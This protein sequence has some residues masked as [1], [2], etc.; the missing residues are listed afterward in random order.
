M[1][2]NHL[3]EELERVKALGGLVLYSRDNP[4]QDPPKIVF[5]TFQRIVDAELP[6]KLLDEPH[7]A[8][9]SGFKDNAT[10][11]MMASHAGVVEL[12]KDLI[13][14]GAE[15]EARDADG[16]TAL[17]YAANMGRD[18]VV[19]LLLQ[20]GADVNAMDNH[21]STPVMFAAQ[22]DH[23]SAVKR[24]ID[25]RAD[26]SIRGDHGLTALGF[27]KQNGHRKTRRILERAGATP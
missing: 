17:M 10:S 25:A 15:I 8:V 11:L 18:E 6:M 27:A 1:T 24:L 21:Q 12:V 23:V 26:L 20:A 4:D 16:Y 14:R 22:H 19:D 13:R 3:V 2:Q 7:P 5:E 9:A